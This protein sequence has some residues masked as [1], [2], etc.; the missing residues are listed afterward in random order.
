MQK[1]MKLKY[2]STYFFVIALTLATSAS[3]AKAG[4]QGGTGAIEITHDKKI[5]WKFNEF[6]LGDNRL[7]CRHVLEGKQADMV[8]K[9]LKALK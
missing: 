9:K 1:I 3:A 2:H 5:V 7:V 6:E 8:R 4:L